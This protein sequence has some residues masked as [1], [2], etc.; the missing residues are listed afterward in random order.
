MKCLPCVR[1]FMCICVEQIHMSKKRQTELNTDYSGAH[2][3]ILL[4]TLSLDN[5]YVAVDVFKKKK[6]IKK[7]MH[8][9][10]K[11]AVNSLLTGYTTYFFP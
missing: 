8:K 1:I 10:Q 3:L 11:D 2:L 6:S 9:M 5:I 7:E 4:Q